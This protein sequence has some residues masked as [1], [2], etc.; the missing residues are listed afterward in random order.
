MSHITDE[1]L[2]AKNRRA[3]GNARA[4]LSSRLIGLTAALGLAFAG[5]SISHMAVASAASTTV[6][7]TANSNKGAGASGR[8]YKLS[9]GFRTPDG[10]SFQI[11]SQLRIGMPR[12]GNSSELQ[13]GQD[14]LLLPVAGTEMVKNTTPGGRAYSGDPGDGDS[15]VAL[16]QS[17]T[18]ICPVPS[19]GPGDATYIDLNQHVYC[20]VDLVAFQDTTTAGK[21]AAGHSVTLAPTPST[22]QDLDYIAGGCGEVPAPAVDTSF[23]YLASHAHSVLSALARPPDLVVLLSASTSP[24]DIPAS[25]CQPVDTGDWIIASSLPIRSCS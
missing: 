21:I 17:P 23:D 19:D 25:A 13:P 14:A 4:A 16:Y 22:C 8:S 1:R 3:P 5:F 7:H 2:R 6:R 24:D 9:V 11:A 18:P 10:Y 15:L 12:R 20:T